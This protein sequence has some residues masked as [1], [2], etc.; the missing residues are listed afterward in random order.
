LAKARCPDAASF[1]RDFNR[2][3]VQRASA[4]LKRSQQPLRVGRNAQIIV[5]TVEKKR[6]GKYE[7]TGILGRGGMGVVYR[8][9]DKRIGRQ[10]AIKT[11][12]ENFSGQPEMLERFYREAQAGILQH[13]NIVIVYDLGDEDGVPFIVMEFVSGDP[14]DKLIASGRHISLIEKL[15]IIEQVCAALGYAHHRG[16]VHRDIKP[17]NVMVQQDGVAKLVDFGIARVQGSSSEGGLT[18]T[19]NVIGTIHYIAPERLRGKPFDGR[20]DIFSTGVMLYLLL[21]GQLPF[22][23]EDMSVLQKLVNEPHP[24]LGTFLANYPPQ[25]DA[26]IEHALAKDPEQRYAT[27]E[28]FAA[29]LHGLGE[30]LKKGQIEELFGD[31]E[32]LTSE[33]QFGRAREVLL[34]LVRIDPQHTGA[35]QLFGIVQQNLARLQR[36]EQ[37]RQLVAEADEAVASQ[38]FTE[39]IGSLDH[40][41]QL[42]PENA[43]LKSRLE[44]VREQKRRYDEMGTLLSQADA[45]RERGDW[46]GALHIAEKAFNLNQQDTKARAL[47]NEISRQAKLAAQKEQIKEMLGKARQELN[48]RRFTGAIEILREVG[49]ID[50]SLP[51]M[52]SMLQTAVAAQEQERR[53]KLIEQIQAEI[54]N[55][56]AAENYDRATELVERAVEQLPSESSLLQLKSRVA[57][58][59]R[60]W[61]T[62][63]L[64]DTTS[65]RAQEAFLQ[66]PGE[67]LLIVQ[68]A[69]QE[70]PGEERLVALE[71]SLR[72]R[73]KAAEKEEIRGRYLRE[74]QGAIDRGQF[75]KA[76]ETLESYQLEFAD[77]AGVGELM[78]Y[79]KREL[80]QQQRRARIGTTVAQAREFLLSEQFD[81][82]IQLLE[83][84]SKE[85]ADPTLARL[86]E[87]ARSQREALLRK[88]EAVMG[89]IL[90][91]R[92]RG[93]LD[94]AIS[95]LQALPASSVAGSQQNTLLKE[96]RN[97]KARK[98]ATETALSA[99]AAAAQSGNF[100]AAIETLQKVQRGWGD[101]PELAQ[102]VAAIE[103]RR[104]QLANENVARSVETARAALLE[105]NTAGAV[106]AL[107]GSAEWFEFAESGQQSDWKRLNAEAAKPVVK[108]ATGTVPMVSAPGEIEIAGPPRNKL[109]I[110]LVG[111]GILAVAGIVIAVVVHNNSAKVVPP[112]VV[113]KTVPGAPVNTAPTGTVVI[114]G[115]VDKGTPDNVQVFVDGALKGFTLGDGS[116]K[117]PLDPGKHSVRFVKPGYTEPPSSSITIAVNSQQTIPFALTQIVGAP[118]PP[119]ASYITILSLPGAAV[120]IDG[121]TPQ[122]T[123]THGVLSAEV[124]P[125]PHTVSVSLNGYQSFN[126]S[127]NLKNGDHQNVPASLNPTPKVVVQNPQIGAFYATSQTVQQ[128]QPTTLKWQTSNANDISI[129]NGIGGVGA[130]GQRD[131]NPSTTTTYT[132]I[133]K[134]NGNPQQE[135]LTITVMAKQ[136]SAP[137]P[138]PAPVA[139][140]A[141]QPVDES[142]VI[143]QTVSSFDAAYNAH[144]M[145]R[146]QTIWTGLKSG[147]AK[148]LAGFFKGNPESHVADS[149]PAGALT[150]S[151]DAANWTCTETST[152]K[153]DGKMVPHTLTIHFTF[154]RRGGNWTIVGRQ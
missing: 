134:G 92:E 54:E 32:R 130:S 125:G 154:A 14:L 151:G 108:R 66:S 79:A 5:D 96:I 74:A 139:A 73:L 109:L 56:L 46:T 57:L 122:N 30:Q 45:L 81:Q 39:A 9:E 94:E 120:S 2:A 118:P 132:L 15:S 144:D 16:V 143:L 28:E 152:F 148:D 90:R 53:R 86:L 20:S 71:E 137:A 42:D 127:F 147:Q 26:I 110:P 64:I 124:K 115:S 44:S 19:G 17:A 145:G 106:E 40:A 43:D 60:A 7:I 138:T 31:A 87:E 59:T 121:A 62:R 72:Q 126:Q 119:P 48:S 63:Q 21:T 88:S 49:K 50:P 146:I 69:L 51:E 141:P 29:D 52:E 85:T 24:P 93:Q 6:I 41:V 133:A 61:R 35:R 89:Q 1:P 123:D 37:V 112:Q 12:T 34:Q 25:L 114:Q 47:Y 98:E 103:A 27:A 68:R 116:L 140:S 65:A 11:L 55:S 22:T 91:H 111:A 83:P 76:I 82:A 135:S 75:D 97:Q 105:G 150:I 113:Y 102:S 149:C 142:S 153:A 10:V 129:D 70:L 100:N 23:G 84:A 36:A 101:T 131:V 18:R 38:R 104:K 95:L 67:A 80:H 78:D 4:A 13:P 8:A 107:K 136:P 117:L 58:Q 128:G 33:Q 3:G 99:A 77:A